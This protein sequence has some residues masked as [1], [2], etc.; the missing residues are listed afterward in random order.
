MAAGKKTLGFEADQ[1]LQDAVKRYETRHNCSSRSEALEQLVTVGIRESRNPILY[2]CKDYAIEGAWYLSL[3]GI[4]TIVMGVMT[5]LMSAGHAIQI[6]AVLVSIGAAL[7]ASVELLR[8]AGGHGSLA[9][10]NP[11]NRHNS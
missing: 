2:R 10:L 7:I 6:A 5:D 9:A 3:I 11:L 8:F 1:E 4:G